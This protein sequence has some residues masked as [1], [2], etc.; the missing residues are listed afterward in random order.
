M[1]PEIEEFA[2]ILVRQVR[3]A[4]VRSCDQLL[5]PIAA[6]PM[7]KRW[8][9]AVGDGQGPS[10]NAVIPDCVDQTVFHLLHAVDQGLLKL[11]FASSNGKNVDLAVEGLGELAGWYAG[12]GGWRAMYSAERFVDD[13]S[14]L[15]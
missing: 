3:D 7:A 12:S 15:T 6:S 11:T 5:Q 14:D 9:K 1:T 8:K 2:R 4:A 10:P 13:F